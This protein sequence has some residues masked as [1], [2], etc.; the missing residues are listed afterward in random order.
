MDVASEPLI[1]VIMN[2]YNS[3]RFLKEALASVFAQSYQ[4]WELVFWDNQSSDASASIIQALADPRIQYFYAPR[5]TGLGE[6]RNL[7]VAQARGEWLAFLDCDDYWTPEK[8]VRQVAMIQSGDQRLGLVYSRAAIVGGK[9][10]GRELAADYKGKALPEGNVLREY[11]MSDNFIPLLSAVVRRDVFWAVG[12]IAPD[13]K[14]AEDF[15]LFAA[16]AAQYEVRADQEISCYYRMHD[17]NLSIRQKE[18]ACEE[19]LRVIEAFWSL[20]PQAQER[21]HEKTRLMSRY[22]VLS[23][24]F[25][26][27]AR[28]NI[29]S[30]FSTLLGHPILTLQTLAHHFK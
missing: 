9:Y 14:Q 5:H 29:L 2:C 12:G 25:K 4:N 13:F 11:L 22:K 21:T 26:I 15:Y 16:I 30:G 19:A 3:D 7:A 28:K 24:F 23:G 8:L 1:S 20:V 27:Q 10:H 18:L 6:A 17:H